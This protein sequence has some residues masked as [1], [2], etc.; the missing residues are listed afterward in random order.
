MNKMKFSEIIEE[1]YRI[2]EGKKCGDFSLTYPNVKKEVIEKRINLL[3]EAYNGAPNPDDFDKECYYRTIKDVVKNYTR[4]KQTLVDFLKKFELYLNRKYIL[5]LKS[6][7]P[8]INISNN[9]ERL[10]YVAK[11]LQTPNRKLNDIYE[12]LWI[13]ERTAENDYKLLL[14]SDSNNA[15]QICGRKFIVSGI[16]RRNGSVTFASTVHPL[17]LTYNISQILVT[18][19]G[20]RLVSQDS[21]MENY[22]FVSAISIWEQLS[23]YAKERILFVSKSL[24]TEDYEWFIKLDDYIRNKDNNTLDSHFLTERQVSEKSNLGCSVLLD[25]MKNNEKCFI[26]YNNEDGSSRIFGNCLLSLDYINKDCYEIT[27]YG[28]KYS[29]KKKNILKSAYSAEGLM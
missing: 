21:S 5:E 3:I 16:Q 12:D 11:E 23:N 8:P 7:F 2:P 22:A 13:G 9:F 24:M 26:E 17:F 28:K 1:F 27:S 4:D 6:F 15:I 18:L 20:L 25:C 19:K 29:L 10:M 14:G